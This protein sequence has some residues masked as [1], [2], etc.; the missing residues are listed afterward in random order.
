MGRLNLRWELESKTNFEGSL[1]AVSLLKTSPSLIGRGVL[2]KKAFLGWESQ[3]KQNQENLSFMETPHWFII[4]VHLRPRALHRWWQWSRISWE[5]PSCLCHPCPK[6]RSICWNFGQEGNNFHLLWIHLWGTR[7][8]ICVLMASLEVSLNLLRLCPIIPFFF[9]FFW[10]WDR[11][12]SALRKK[13]HGEHFV[14]GADRNNPS[15]VQGS[16]SQG[17][18]FTVVP[19]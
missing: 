11:P 14:P 19:Q 13:Y 1:G 17:T 15:S 3:E 4:F 6:M 5:Q 8:H 9:F 10:L 2:W 18:P 12:G 16:L 7:R